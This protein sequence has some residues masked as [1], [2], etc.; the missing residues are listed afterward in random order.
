M[1]LYSNKHQEHLS[2]FKEG[3]ERILGK[4]TVIGSS[5]DSIIKEVSQVNQSLTNHAEEADN[6]DMEMKVVAEGANVAFVDVC[7]SSKSQQ[8]SI[9]TYTNQ[10]N[11]HMN[12]LSTQSETVGDICET[13]HT[14]K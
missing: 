13:M 7:D 1:D 2:E 9:E 3:T 5:A 14:K 11:R 10:S 8:L 4:N 6:N 12:D